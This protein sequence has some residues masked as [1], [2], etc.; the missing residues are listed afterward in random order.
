MNVPAQA[1]VAQWLASFKEY[2]IRAK[3]A[4]FNLDDV[5]QKLSPKD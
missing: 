4:S 5:M 3:P 1:A 2:P